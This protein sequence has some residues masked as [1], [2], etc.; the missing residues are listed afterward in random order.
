MSKRLII[1]VIIFVSIIVVSLIVYALIDRQ[2][3]QKDYTTGPGAVLEPKDRRVLIDVREPSE[4]LSGHANSAINVPLGDILAGKSFGV[5]KDRPIQVY[6]RTGIRAGQAKTKLEKDGYKN[7][8]NIGGLA[9]W[10]KYGGELCKSDKPD[11]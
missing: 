4:Y 10:E 7:V 2:K 5:D 3:V 9:D 11:C 8:T 6:C 1:A